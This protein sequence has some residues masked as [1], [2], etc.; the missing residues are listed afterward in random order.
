MSSDTSRW[1]LIKQRAITLDGDRVVYR[2]AGKEPVLLL[3]HGMAGSSVTWKRVM[4]AFAKRFT[5]LAPDLLGQGQS[6]KPRGEYSL[7]AH[8]NTLRD[9]MDT[10]GYKR[11]RKRSCFQRLAAAGG[12]QGHPRQPP[13]DLRGG[14]PLPAL[15]GAR[16]LRCGARRLHRLHQ[17]CPPASAIS[18]AATRCAKLTADRERHGD[19]P[20]RCRFDRPLTPGHF[21][22]LLSTV[23]DE[24]EMTLWV[25]PTLKER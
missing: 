25:S 10:L 2:V 9:L 21:R 20:S 16:A 8:A 14:G 18:A 17:A 15:R 1:A 4:P 6:D 3:V 23:A 24:K 7:G 13:R 11:A 12:A 5:V 19:H 22:R